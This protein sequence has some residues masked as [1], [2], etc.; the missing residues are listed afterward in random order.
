MKEAIK[1]YLERTG[2]EDFNPKA[3][4]F[5]MDGVLVDSMPNHAIAWQRSM[6]TF[7]ISMS[8]TD[9][10]LTEGARG[11]DTIRNMVRKQKGRDITEEEAQVMYDEKTRQFGLLPRPRLMPFALQLQEKVYRMGLTIGVVTGSGQKPLINRLLRDF[12]RVSRERLVTAYD[13]KNGKPMPDPYL[14]G[15]EKCS[16]KPW[17]TIVVENAPLGVMAGVAAKALTIAVNTGRMPDSALEEAGADMVLPS[18]EALYDI[19]AIKQTQEVKWERMYKYVLEFYHKH[20]RRPSKHKPEE[21]EMHNWLKHNKKILNQGKMKAE[22][23]RKFD[24]LIKL[25]E[26]YRRLNQYAYQETKEQRIL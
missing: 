16:T 18:M 7:G 20:H 14:A 1:R 4:L 2:F 26:K 17:Q 11:V 13:I 9:A 6:A 19:F 23:Q 25:G 22:R 15:M 10:Y 3:V 5:D 21:H 24:R 12:P 8:E